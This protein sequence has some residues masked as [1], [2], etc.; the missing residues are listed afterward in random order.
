[1]L[2]DSRVI[3]IGSTHTSVKMIKIY[4]PR[5]LIHN[6]N[7]WAAKGFNFRTWQRDKKKTRS[8]GLTCTLINWMF[9]SLAR[10]I[11]CRKQ[12]QGKEG[13]SNEYCIKPAVIEVKL[14]ISQNISYYHPAKFKKS[15]LSLGYKT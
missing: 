10:C 8:E 6:I 13:T 15:P 4:E 7:K 11:M 3:L 12:K 5:Q 1:M 14:Y 2:C 9:V